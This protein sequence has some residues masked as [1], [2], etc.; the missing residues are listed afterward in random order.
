MMYELDREFSR[1]VKIE[2]DLPLI[3][4]D[5]SHIFGQFFRWQL[6]IRAQEVSFPF[7][8]CSSENPFSSDDEPNARRGQRRFLRFLQSTSV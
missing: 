2:H 8:I 3:M 6:V 1:F 5:F 4:E 7:D